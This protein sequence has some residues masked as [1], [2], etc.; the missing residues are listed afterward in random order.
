MAVEF[1]ES[2]A[3]GQW[4]VPPSTDV[5]ELA[6]KGGDVL[7][8]EGI[9]NERRPTANCVIAS[10][11]QERQLT[12]WHPRRFG[13]A[14]EG[15]HT[16]IPSLRSGS[17]TAPAKYGYEQSKR[18]AS[19][20]LS[21]S[22]RRSRFEGNSRGRCKPREWTERWRSSLVQQLAHGTRSCRHMLSAFENNIIGELHTRVCPEL[23]VTCVQTRFT[24]WT[25]RA[26]FPLKWFRVAV[27]QDTTSRASPPVRSDGK[28]VKRQAGINQLGGVFINGR[29]LPDYIRRRIVELALMGTFRRVT[30]P[31]LA[32]V[33][34]NARPSPHVGKYSKKS[35]DRRRHTQCGTVAVSVLTGYFEAV[36]NRLK[37][38]VRP[39]DISRQLLVSHG[40]VSKILTRF[41]ETGSIKPG[42][43]GSPKGKISGRGQ[44]RQYN[45]KRIQQNAAIERQDASFA[46]LDLSNTVSSA[47]NTVDWY[48][49]RRR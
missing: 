37:F 30:I 14:N 8:A 28:S 15:T 13:T 49:F 1:P 18:A 46:G 23:C 25:S 39:C 11:T 12:Q 33:Q 29:P 44:R 35:D 19:S 21:L 38:Q 20:P 2:G 36:I 34:V 47:Q 16:F 4:F 6:R 5:P 3:A 9:R 24:V 32:A 7:C 42:S 22:L 43:T 26:E 45:L 48:G 10:K 31:D 41:Y 40:C 27:L 17:L